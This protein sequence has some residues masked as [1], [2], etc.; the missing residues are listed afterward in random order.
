MKHRFNGVVIA[1]SALALAGCG[2]SIGPTTIDTEWSG[3]IES[4]ET[5]EIKGINGD[6]IASHTSGNS[7][8]VTV[9]KVGY[10]S[11]PADV[12]IDVITHSGGVTICAVYP[13]VPGEPA[14]EC[15]PGD[16]GRMNIRNNDVEV[17][18]RVAIPAGVELFGSTINGSIVGTDLASYAFAATVNGDIQITTSELAAGSTVNGTITASIG[19]ENWDRDLSFATVNGDAWVRVPSGTNADVNL[20]TV[21]GIVTADMRLTSVHQG[22]VRGTLGNGGRRLSVS[23]VNGNIELERGG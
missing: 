17:T 8:V 4:G 10:D 13:D 14:N 15:A 21:N 18:F 12:Q 16:G 23:T 9:E 11:D 19:L 20:S 3:S 5:V 6:I 22:D 2:D 1:A 7:V